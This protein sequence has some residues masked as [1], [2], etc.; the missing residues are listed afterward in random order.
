MICGKK[1]KIFLQ[2][3]YEILEI[4]KTFEK[5]LKTFKENFEQIL[6]KF[7]EISLLAYSF[8]IKFPIIMYPVKTFFWRETSTPPCPPRTDYVYRF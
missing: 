2:N 8:Q 1:L 7:F 6:K 4:F 5:I 3:L